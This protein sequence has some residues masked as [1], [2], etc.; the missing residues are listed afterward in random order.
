MKVEK[1]PGEGMAS[2]F[3]RCPDVGGTGGM[4]GSDVRVTPRV[5]LGLV[6]LLRP[7]HNEERLAIRDCAPGGGGCC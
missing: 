2:W 4:E 1:R 5:E 3:E 7:D 6:D